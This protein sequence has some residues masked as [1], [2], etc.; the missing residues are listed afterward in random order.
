MFQRVLICTDLTDGLQRLMQ[1]VPSLAAGGMKSIVFL[2]V[3]PLPDDA[4]PRQDDTRIQNLRDRLSAHLS[5]AP[6]GV[7]VRLEVLMGK[8]VEL[9]LSTI[10]THGSELLLIGMPSRSLLNE[11]LF[12]STTMGVCERVTIPVLT[13]RPQLISSLTHEELDLRCR[14]LFRHLLIPY[15]GSK[16]GNY[17]IGKIQELVRQQAPHSLEHCLLSTVVD[18][19]SRNPNLGNMELQQAQV[20]LAE[21]S[22]RMEAAGIKAETQVRSGN[23]IVEL[24]ES[25]QDWGASAIATA[26]DSL[27]GLRELPAPSF[28]G[29]LLRKSWHPV[30]YFPVPRSNP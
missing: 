23:A 13:F 9:I 2:H 26:S 3:V 11:K 20:R 18:E 1:F 15:D 30:L 14:H 24:L 10:K 29:E 21:A 12:G 17:L 19:V 6:E 22:T 27:G 16:A 25:A 8:P 7:E 28:S 4:V 5:P